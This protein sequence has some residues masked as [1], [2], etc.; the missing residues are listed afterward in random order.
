MIHSTK[1]KHGVSR[2][3]PFRVKI[4]RVDRWTKYE[5]GIDWKILKEAIEETEKEGS[6]GIEVESVKVERL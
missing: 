3:K 6:E 1:L 2:K 4:T 5:G